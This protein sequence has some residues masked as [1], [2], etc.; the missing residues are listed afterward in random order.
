VVDAK[1]EDCLWFHDGNIILQAGFSLFKLHTSILGARSG[2]LDKFLNWGQVSESSAATFLEG[3]VLDGYRVVRLSDDGQDAR[4]FFLAIYDS[5][6]VLTSF[7]SLDASFWSIIF[8]VGYFIFLT[9]ALFHRFF[10]RPPAHTSYEVVLAILKLSTK[11]EVAYL[12]KRALAHLFLSYPLTLDQWDQR[13]KVSTLGAELDIDAWPGSTSKTLKVIEAAKNLKA[14]WILPGAYYDLATVSLEVLFND[15]KWNDGTI[16]IDTKND[17]LIG[18]HKQTNA[19]RS[20][21]LEFLYSNPLERC[22]QKDVCGEERRRLYCTTQEWSVTKPLE[23]MVDG[24]W[25]YFLGDLCGL[26]LEVSK[27]QFQ[28]ARKE[29]WEKL[30]EI[31]GLPKWEVLVRMYGEAVG[32]AQAMHLGD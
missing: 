24:D 9:A 30:P 27:V 2:V 15:P 7:P 19:T 31:F 26:C 8:L 5:G 23:V 16:N 10:E 14:P 25:E 6:S 11:Y 3:C 20:Q 28:R 18:Y 1:I 21:M 22:I 32:D 17:I 29:F 12:R 4:Y 13:Q